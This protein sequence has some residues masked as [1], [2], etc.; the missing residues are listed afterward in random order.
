VSGGDVLHTSPLLIARGA[1]S[2]G[3]SGGRRI[4]VASAGDGY[5]VRVEGSGA[6]EDHAAGPLQAV[7]VFNHAMRDAARAGPTSRPEPAELTVGALE[8]ARRARTL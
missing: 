2:A 6:R 3:G 1:R 5:L 8:A 7:Q 4:V